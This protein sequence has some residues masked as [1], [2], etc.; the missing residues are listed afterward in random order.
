[1]DSQPLWPE[2]S[3]VNILCFSLLLT[4]GARFITFC[5]CARIADT[6]RFP[7]NYF[8]TGDE[9]RRQV[10]GH[11]P[12]EPSSVCQNATVAQPSGRTRSYSTRVGTNS[13]ERFSA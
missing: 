4:Y 11:A 5:G 1:M 3:Y 7:D 12:R 10:I 2:P 9:R 13:R 8:L 6:L